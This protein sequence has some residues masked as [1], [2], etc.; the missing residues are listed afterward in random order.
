MPGRASVMPPS[1][2]T[3][4]IAGVEPTLMSATAT[5][6]KPGSARWLGPVLGAIV[7]LAATVGATRLLLSGFE[8]EVWSDE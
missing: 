6:A 1:D 2:S 5:P 3:T 8:A 7:L 4:D